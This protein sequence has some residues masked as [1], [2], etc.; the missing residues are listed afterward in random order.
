MSGTIFGFLYGSIFGFE[1]I[2]PNHPVFG[3]FVLIQPI[4]NILQILG[5]AIG[6]G[7]VLL[8]IGL[9]LNLYATSRAR[10]WAEFFFGHNGLAAAV[11]YWSLLGLVASLAFPSFPIP[12]A[13][14]VVLAILGALL[15]VVFAEPLRHWMEGHYPLIEG[16]KGVFAV[17][18]FFELLEKFISMFSNTLSFVRVGAFAI[19]HAGFTGAVFVIAR[20]LSGGQEVGIVY[21]AVVVLGNLGVILLEGFIVAIQTMRLHYYEFFSKFFTGGGS[22][23]EPLALAN[24]PEN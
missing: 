10:N 23:Y 21:W 2:L 5:L 22:P 20:L 16:S 18:A 17:Q 1:E 6:T 15:G 13:V 7:I 24:A 14:F 12:S 9:L 8:N 19:V 4:H 11:L 3:R